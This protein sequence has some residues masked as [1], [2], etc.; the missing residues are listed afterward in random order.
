MLVSIQALVLNA[1]PYYNEPGF[2]KERG[3]AM[4][5]E[6]CQVSSVSVRFDRLLANPTVV[7]R[8]IFRPLQQYNEV[9]LMKML[10]HMSK[11]LDRP[12]KLWDKLI[13]NHFR[14]HGWRLYHR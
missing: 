2:E 14:K 1:D 9:V 10:E 3:S 12:V 6:K 7:Q 8:F 4:G 5:A 11:L 13:V